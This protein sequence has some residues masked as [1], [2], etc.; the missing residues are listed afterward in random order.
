MNLKFRIQIVVV[1]VSSVH[2]VQLGTTGGHGV[3]HFEV[4]EPP[5]TWFCGFDVE[6]RLCL[7]RVKLEMKT[8][9]RHVAH[10]TDSTESIE[11]RIPINAVLVQ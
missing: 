4:T 9:N 6:M 2:E 10:S 3:T 7:I 11:R 8:R 5:L 1:V